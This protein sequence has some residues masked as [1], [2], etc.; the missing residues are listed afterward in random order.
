MGEIIPFRIERQA[1]GELRISEIELAERLGH[2]DSRHFRRVLLRNKEDL[3]ELGEFRVT[4]TQNP[5][6]GRPERIHW[7]NRGQAIHAV[8]RSDTSTSR[9]LAIELT[10]AFDHLLS[11]TQRHLPV[12]EWFQLQIISDQIS[13]WEREYPVRFFDHLHRVLGLTKPG[14]NNHS[15]CG[16][17]INR[18]IYA[19]LFG[20]LG[21]DVIREA[22]P[23]D[24]E[25]KRAVRHH[26]VLKEKHKPALRQHIDKVAGL[27]AN[28]VS[29]NHFD[30]M[31]N[32]AF[33][34]PD[35]QIGMM[36]GEAPKTARE[37]TP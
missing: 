5:N 7:L 34:Q 23:A 10:R 2:K 27:L 24:D 21:L 32:R 19:H 12:R 26:Q 3:Q 15:N 20:A 4:L 14:R 6:G 9:R 36:F 31:F 37:A 28:A 33:P 35:T 17:F 11:Q 8:Y 13:I 29:L 1:D 16:H 25:Y 22:N 30:D 18:Y